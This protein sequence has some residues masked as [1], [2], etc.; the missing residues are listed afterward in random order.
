MM[1]DGT[2]PDINDGRRVDVEEDF[3]IR[4]RMLPQAKCIR[5]VLEGNE[6]DRPDFTS[7]ALEYSGFWS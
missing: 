5:W 6:E 3:Q 2:T 1:P 7:V 4:R